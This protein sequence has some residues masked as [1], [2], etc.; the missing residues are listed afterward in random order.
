MFVGFL[1]R[2]ITLA[3][4][5][6][7]KMNVLKFWPEGLVVQM[8]DAFVGP[9]ELS[10]RTPLVIRLCASVRERECLISVAWKP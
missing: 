10:I 3:M 1:T 5:L 7:P 8:T 2:P 4:S 9:E 6:T